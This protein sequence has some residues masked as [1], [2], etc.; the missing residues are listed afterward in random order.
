MVNDKA[1]LIH[2]VKQTLELEPMASIASQGEI[3]RREF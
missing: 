3:P 1:Y 2:E